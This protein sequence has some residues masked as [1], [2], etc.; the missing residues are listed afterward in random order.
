MNKKIRRI[1][2]LLERIY[3]RPGEDEIVVF[4]IAA[5]DDIQHDLPGLEDLS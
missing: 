4:I 2:Y 1:L 5:A 3:F